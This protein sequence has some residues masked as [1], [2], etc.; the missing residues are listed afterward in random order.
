[1]ARFV[2]ICCSCDYAFSITCPALKVPVAPTQTSPSNGCVLSD[3]SLSTTYTPIWA[4]GDTQIAINGRLATDAN[5]CN[6]LVTCCISRSC[7]CIQYDL[8]AYPEMF[9]PGVFYAQFRQVTASYEVSPYSTP[10]CFCT[11]QQCYLSTSPPFVNNSNC[12]SI[13][14]T[15]AN[16]TSGVVNVARFEFS[17]TC[18]FACVEYDCCYPVNGSNCTITFCEMKCVSGNIRLAGTYWFRTSSLPRYNSACQCTSLPCSYC[19]F[20]CSYIFALACDVP[21]SSCTFCSNLAL[22]GLYSPTNGFQNCA[23]KTISFKFEVSCDCTFTTGVLTACGPYNVF[24]PRTCFTCL[25]CQHFVRMCVLCGATPF[26]QC[27]TW[28]NVVLPNGLTTSNLCTWTPD[29]NYAISSGTITTNNVIAVLG[30]GGGGPGECLPDCDCWNST[31][32]NPAGSFWNCTFRTPAA[33]GSGFVCFGTIEGKC[34]CQY[35]MIP[36]AQMPGCLCNCSCLQA[37]AYGG[38]E[39]YI[40]CLLGCTCICHTNGLPSIF[41]LKTADGVAK[42]LTICAPGGCC[43]GIGG[44]CG[45]FPAYRGEYYLHPFGCRVECGVVYE[46]CWGGSKGSGPCLVFCCFPCINTLSVYDDCARYPLNRSVGYCCYTTL[47]CSCQFLAAII[48]N[49]CCIFVESSGGGTLKNNTY[50][51]GGFPAR[52]CVAGILNITPICPNTSGFGFGAGGPGSCSYVCYASTITSSACYRMYCSLQFY[53]FTGY[54][55]GGGGGMLWL[56]HHA[57]ACCPHKG[58]S[59]DADTRSCTWGKSGL[60]AFACQGF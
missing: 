57:Y 8:C 35:T 2:S 12:Q 23:N 29:V 10:C 7:P 33:G 56:C 36:A 11:R 38:N 25:A 17:C 46:G 44:N 60:I 49:T 1:M 47:S 39:T 9:V 14:L 16:G 41:E 54:G 20:G 37:Y 26:V 18:D 43:C 32:C 55:G 50:G 51:Y 19:I 3:L 45:A 4:Y 21:C 58:G 31:S 5:M 27:S 34:G 6:L 15:S 24:I 53:P 40:T 52:M 22:Y 59:C 28:N 48:C 13:A 42:I 30:I